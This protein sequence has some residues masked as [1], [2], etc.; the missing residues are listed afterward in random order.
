MIR[1]N[2]SGGGKNNYLIKKMTLNEKNEG[3]TIKAWA[4]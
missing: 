4:L 1:M 3:F 2:I